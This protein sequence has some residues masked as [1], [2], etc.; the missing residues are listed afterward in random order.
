VIFGAD[1]H[2]R[3]IGEEAFRQSGIERIA[4]SSKVEIVGKSCFCECKSLKEVIFGADSQLREI[5]EWAFRRS[6]L[7][8]IALPSKVEIVGKACF[9]ECESLREVIFGADSQ[10][11]EIQEGAFQYSGIERIVIP[12]GATCAANAFPDGCVVDKRQPGETEDESKLMDF[13]SFRR[14]RRIG[15]G[16]SGYVELWEDSNKRQLAI[17]FIEVGREFDWDHFEREVWILVNGSDHACIL[18]IVGWCPPVGDF[19]PRIATEYMKTLGVRKCR[20][21]G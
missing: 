21:L 17:K 19:E 16:G 11:R 20:M 6:G 8:R 15:K 18:S 13:S 1:S 14:I 5:G 4:L 2:L 7:E 10:L 3:D 12:S 9:C